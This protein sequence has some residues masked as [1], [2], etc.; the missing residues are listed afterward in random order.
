MQIGCDPKADST[1]NLTGGKP[2]RS[3]LETL[4]E[5][6]SDITASDIIVKGSCGCWC[7]ESGG[8]KPGTGCAGRGIITTFETLEKLKVYDIVKPDIVL[9]DVLGDVVCGGF[10]MPIRQGYADE[11]IIVTSGEKMSL[12]A[13]RNIAGAVNEFGCRGYA[14][15]RGIIANLKGLN[16]EISTIEGLSKEL[17]IPVL[18]E[19]PRHC[20]IQQAEDNCTTVIEAFPESPLT[21]LYLNL[22][23]SIV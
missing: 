7:A 14:S 6:G 5:K 17:G 2:I 11:V 8:P 19:I 18:A 22:A 9:Y 10:A 4:R 1:I 23:N 12:Y 21:K 15:L 16:N 3:V 20:S 13:A